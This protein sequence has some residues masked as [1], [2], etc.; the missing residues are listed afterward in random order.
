MFC[1][2]TL[3]FPVESALR[4]SR[5]CTSVGLTRVTPTGLIVHAASSV[6]RSSAI[7]VTHRRFTLQ[8]YAGREWFGREALGALRLVH[9]LAR[10]RRGRRLGAAAAQM[11][12][13]RG[14]WRM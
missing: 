4:V 8:Y 14:G 11:D 1:V 13:G 5:R 2:K 6:I 7:V 9:S 3:S 12:V 10:R